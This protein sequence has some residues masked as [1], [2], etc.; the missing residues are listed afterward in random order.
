MGRQIG[1]R[2][3]SSPPPFFFPSCFSFVLFLFLSFFFIFFACVFLFPRFL[4]LS[5]SLPSLF[6]S[7]SFPSSLHSSCSTRVSVPLA[8]SKP[9]CSSPPRSAWSNG[10]RQLCSV[11]LS[12]QTLI[13]LAQFRQRLSACQ[14]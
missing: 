4:C 11:L 7:T 12:S 5:L 3:R 1:S 10:H 8:S 6:S 2:V 13:L 9:P 14:T